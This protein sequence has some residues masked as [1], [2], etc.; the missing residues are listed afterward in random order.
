MADRYERTQGVIARTYEFALPREL[1]DQGRLA[2]ADDICAT[3]FARYPHTWAVHCPEVRT[4][5]QTA[6]EGRE[7]QQPHLHVMFS[8]RREDHPSERTADAWFAR[9]ANPDAD[10][11]TGGVKKDRRWDRKATLQGLRHETAILINAALEREGQAVAVSHH[12]LRA[13]GHERRPERVHARGDAVMLKKYG[14]EKPA[15]VPER[16]QEQV[17]A[18]QERWRET[19]ATRTTITRDFRG[20]ENAMNVVTWHS[21][22]EREGIRDIS[23]E[24]IVDHT[25]DRFWQHD[26]S[27]V[28]EAEREASFVRAIEREYART[29]RERPDPTERALAPAHRH[30]QGRAVTRTRSREHLGLTLGRDH[31]DDMGHG[32]HVQLEA[33]EHTR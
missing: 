8:T 19:L 7:T 11:L 1:S 16:Q 32:A 3:F 15:H 17:A 24:A 27:P 21:Q 28:R 4:T 33:R 29:G 14:W 5:A 13:Q 30:A 10:P 20:W 12:T 18:M 23:R 2:L 6:G 26:R 9:A 25:R 22:K 31:G